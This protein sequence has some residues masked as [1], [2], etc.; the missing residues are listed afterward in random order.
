MDH[1]RH[2]KHKNKQLKNNFMTINISINDIDKFEKKRT[3]K[4]ENIHKIHLVWLL[5][6]ISYIPEPIKKT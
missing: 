3:N 2:E 6:L 1:L 5:W 4:E